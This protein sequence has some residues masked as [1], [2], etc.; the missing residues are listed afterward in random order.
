MIWLGGYLACG[1][2]MTGAVFEGVGLLCL[3]GLG[4]IGGGQGDLMQKS[5]I[6]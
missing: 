5:E 3:G 2:G 6:Y 4:R 1:W